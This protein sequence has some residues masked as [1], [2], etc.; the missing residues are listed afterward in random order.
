MDSEG[1]KR[2]LLE[3]TQDTKYRNENLIS[4][5][6]KDPSYIR[7]KV[8]EGMYFPETL[9]FL[10]N[11][12][13]QLITIDQQVTIPFFRMIKFEELIEAHCKRISEDAKRKAEVTKNKEAKKK[14]MDIANNNK[15][16]DEK[17]FLGYADE[18]TKEWLI[19]HW[20]ADK[21]SFFE[22][23]YNATI[24]KRVE[25]Y[26]ATG[27][28]LFRI[29]LDKRHDL[30][31]KVSERKGRTI[32]R[33]KNQS[34]HDL[35]YE[36]F[37]S[38]Y[39]AITGEKCPFRNERKGSDKK[40]VI[41]LPAKSEEIRVNLL[42][43]IYSK[44]FPQG[45]LHI[46][47]QEDYLNTVLKIEKLDAEYDY[48]IKKTYLKQLIWERIKTDVLSGDV[49]ATID[50]SGNKLL[51]RKYTD[52]TG[53]FCRLFINCEK[54]DIRGMQVYLEMLV[55]RLTP[56]EQKGSLDL[57]LFYPMNTIQK[58]H[59][60]IKPRKNISDDNTK[61]KVTI[62]IK[63]FVVRRHVF[64]CMHKKHKLEDLDAVFKIMNKNIQM[65]EVI[66]P[67]GYCKQC[68][69]YFILE[70]T[71]QQL[72][73][74]GIVACRSTDEKS[75]LNQT[76]M[77]GKKLAQESILMQFG[78]TVS[79]A[80]G[81]SEERRQKIL[82]VLVDN[83]ILTKNEI[84]SYLDFFISQRKSDKFALAVAKW[85]LDRKYISNYKAGEYSRIGVIYRN[86]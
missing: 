71:Y 16:T 56:E 85:E 30:K 72:C 61:R 45:L 49:Y 58:A 43:N 9:E 25:W 13:Q 53:I 50:E 84:I 17:E 21:N 7:R 52:G 46:K 83:H 15:V 66:V 1:L 70:S 5:Y 23:L 2:L 77:N 20:N 48:L 4:I 63:D 28:K 67:V 29:V 59:V 69:T 64:Q 44:I 8:K 36:Q 68:K 55:S 65:E 60:N 42:G 73:K 27:G 47:K 86:N 54:V 35:S 51:L 79:Q 34:K 32:Y 37:N 31:L 6:L 74:K 19:S 80:E 39:V 33:L 38:M 62:G 78:Y 57:A 10:E 14:E 26:Q 3:K 40:V 22:Y 81:L 11:N 82:S 18:I 12:I 24:T 76:Y 75:Y 41:K